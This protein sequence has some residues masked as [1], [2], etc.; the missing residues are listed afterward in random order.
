M[1]MDVEVR[2][3]SH[4]EDYSIIPLPEKCNFIT[5]LYCQT[6]VRDL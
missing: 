2:Y 1:R 4:E 6:P 3:E 5:L